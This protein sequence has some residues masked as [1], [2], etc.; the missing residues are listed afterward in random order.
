MYKEK[1]GVER[2]KEREDDKE[3]EGGQEEGGK[4]KREGDRW[5]DSETR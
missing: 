3:S 5:R 4:V 1:K 2:A